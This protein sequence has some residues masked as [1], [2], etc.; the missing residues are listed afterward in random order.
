[1]AKTAGG[2]AIYVRVSS[3]SQNYKSQKPDLKKWIKANAG[4]SKVTWY[5][6]SFTGTSMQ[7]PA[8]QQ[9]TEDIEAGRIKTVVVW[10]LNR[11]GRNCAG[12]C[13][14][15]QYLCAKA[16][17]LV[18]IMESF[19]LN[20]P[21]GKMIASILSSI[22]E[23]SVEIQKEA[24][25]AGIEAAR[26]S[27]E[28]ITWGG[29]VKGRVIIGKNKVSAIK[30]LHRNGTPIAEIARLLQVSRPTVYKFVGNP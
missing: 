9:M 18:S 24:Q 6:D 11:I 4:K 17:N 7:R 16:V 30:K 23:Y 10:R 29:S 20:T 27:P 13:A 8:F 19:D 21:H 2:I 22:S 15:F 26:N 1:M 14:F 5:E 3:T 28:G 25:M 12:M